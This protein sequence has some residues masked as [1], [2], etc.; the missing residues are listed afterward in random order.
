MTHRFRSFR[1][2]YLLTMGVTGASLAVLTPA[3]GVDVPVSD[4]TATIT[5][6]INDEPPIVLLNDPVDESGGSYHYVGSHTDPDDKWTVSW[7]YWIDPDPFEGNASFLGTAEVL[8]TSGEE[9]DFNVMIDL[10]LCPFIEGQSLLG[11]FVVVSIS[12]NEN[13]GQMA[14]VNQE[15]VWAVMADG[16]VAHTIFDAPFLLGSTGAG[17]ATLSNSFGTP[18]PSQ[19]GPPIYDTAG[20]QHLFSLTDGDTAK[21]TTSLFAGSDS[22]N[23]VE[24][25]D[26]SYP[27]GDLNQDGV[28]DIIDLM[29]LLGDWGRCS[30]CDA[31]L[32]DDGTVDIYD[33]MILLGNWS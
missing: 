2:G 21:F 16:E 11:A 9:V 13:G 27:H 7:N 24:C 29:M 33:L 12:T 5:I 28:V 4:V 18:F 32:N 1:T 17:T 14:D 10:P 30:S 19:P 15:S 25:S 26:D 23:F 8:N 20:V 6:G 22:G 3:M 31:D